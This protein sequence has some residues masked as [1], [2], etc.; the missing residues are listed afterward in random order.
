MALNSIKNNRQI[1]KK[2]FEDQKF[3]EFGV[4]YVKI[5]QTN[6]WKYTIIDDLIPVIVQPNSEGK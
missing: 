2:M 3:I 1:L 5:F 4:Y 6:V